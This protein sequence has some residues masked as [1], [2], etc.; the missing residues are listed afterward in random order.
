MSRNGAELR[1][2][3]KKKMSKKK[4]SKKKKK[5]KKNDDD[6]IHKVPALE[7]S[8]KQRQQPPIHKKQ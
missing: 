2:G 7:S 5:K 8:A 1:R 4:N 6:N 3:A